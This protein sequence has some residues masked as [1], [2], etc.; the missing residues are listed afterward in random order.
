M[1]SGL[2]APIPQW[3]RPFH[4]HYDDDSWPA[5]QLETSLARLQSVQAVLK[6]MAYDLSKT[7]AGTVAV[8]RTAG[9]FPRPLG[10]KGPAPFTAY[11]AALA[12]AL[13][14]VTSTIVDIRTALSS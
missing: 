10:L 1:S 2:A 3:P 13:V 9:T 14:D 7:T 11:E 12:Q 5:R 8:A 6:N 4:D